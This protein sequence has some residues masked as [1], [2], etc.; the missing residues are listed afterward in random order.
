MLTLLFYTR[1]HCVPSKGGTEHTTITVARK[2][3]EDY[4]IHSISA[5]TY[6]FVGEANCFDAEYKLSKNKKEATEKIRNIINKHN[7][8]FVIIQGYFHEIDI[9]RHAIKDNSKCHL[10]FTHHFNP[11]WEQ[12]KREEVDE[13]MK[14]SKG[15]KHAKYR[16]KLKLFPIFLKLNK[17]NLSKRYRSAY[18]YSD[19]VVLLSNGYIDKFEKLGHFCDHSK[20]CVIPNARSFTN[21]FD[22]ANYSEKEK[23]VLIVSRLDERQKRIHLALDIWKQVKKNKA[24]KDWR[25]QIVGDGDQPCVKEYIKWSKENK[26]PEVDFFGRRVPLPF[27]QKASIF[28][29]TSACEGL[30]LTILEAQQQAVVPIVFDTFDSIHDIINSG[31]N[32]YIINETDKCSY[33]K[34]LENLLLNDDLRKAMAERALT[35]QQKFSREVIMEKWIEMFKDIV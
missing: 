31:Q 27:Y 13:K 11:G 29:M 24:L 1:Y 22:I 32:G 33:I 6:D 4:S 28:M 17:H 10:I 20:F 12:L 35:S 19:K 21:S 23:I 7:V 34:A 5:F 25:L 8:D 14:R 30:P 2:L 15:Y 16:V 18:R 9:F 26:I 3:L